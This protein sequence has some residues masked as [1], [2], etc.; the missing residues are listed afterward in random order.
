MNSINRND[1]E[2]EFN[3]KS[4]N[5]AHPK[6]MSII[7]F[8]S[9]YDRD[10]VNLSPSY[11][12]GEVWDN[13]RKRELIKSIL[14]NIRL[15]EIIINTKSDNDRM[16]DI[17]DGKQ[18]LTT[19]FN[20]INN[21]FALVNSN[22]KVYFN[23]FD[24]ELQTDIK[25]SQL[26]LVIYKD[27]DETKQR[28]IFERINYGSPLKDGE[29]LKGSNSKGLHLIKELINTYSN[30]FID[31]KILDDRG[32]YYLKFGVVISLTQNHIQDASSGVVI[33][34][35]FKKWNY[36]PEE[37]VK[38][39][40]LCKQNL[41]KLYEIWTKINDYHLERFNKTLKKLWNWN[42]ILFNIYYI[43]EKINTTKDLNDLVQ[44]N[45]F[46]YHLKYIEKYKTY[47]KPL[48]DIDTILV[49]WDKAG[50]KN[51]NNKDMYNIRCDVMQT[52]LKLINKS[53]PR[54]IKDK[55]KNIHFKNKT[56][57]S[58]IACINTHQNVISPTNFQC[59]HIISK[60]NGGLIHY[61]I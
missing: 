33:L 55:I 2:R 46:M 45:K 15:P 36:T 6:T 58:C 18:R 16:W 19:L 60:Y 43:N 24:T 40:D 1:L 22:T 28:D 42:E 7:S 12:R 59:G 20:F 3:F 27:L 9:K 26:Q 53:I 17:I 56:Q 10:Q 57:I 25:E 52:V 29:K 21:E 11:Q 48:I 35:Y 61:K 39:L 31:Y 44:F 47:F 54:S 41:N 34:K 5:A 4:I 23:D 38:I 51:S 8:K 32:S 30:H 13:S 37:E 50:R 14:E 49:E